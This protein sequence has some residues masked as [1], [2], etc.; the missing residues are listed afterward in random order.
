VVVCDAENERLLARE[1]A[2]S[3]A[4]VGGPG[5]AAADTRFGDRGG[6]L[7]G[8]GHGLDARRIR[9]VRG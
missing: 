1:Q 6:D 8:C 4:V 5:E 3:N 9:H 7:N 2:F